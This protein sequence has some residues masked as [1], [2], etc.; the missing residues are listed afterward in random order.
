VDDLLAHPDLARHLREVFDFVLMGRAAKRFEE[1]RQS[2][3][4]FDF[5]EAC[6]RTNRPWDAVVRDLIVARPKQPEERGVIPFL[7]ER[8]NHP[9]A[10]AEAL[11]PVVFGVQIK[12]AQCHGHMV[13]REIK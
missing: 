1:Q 6:F 5:L 10:M 13:A 8:Q 4:W 12:C 2:H 3:R 11:A 9:Q 7:F